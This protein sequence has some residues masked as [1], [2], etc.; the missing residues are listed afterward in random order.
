MSKGFRKAIIALSIILIAVSAVALTLYV[1]SNQVISG[2]LTVYVSI[3][4]LIDKYKVTL[5]GYGVVL[6]IEDYLIHPSRV[7]YDL[8]LGVCLLACD[9]LIEVRYIDILP[10]IGHV[11]IDS[12]LGNYRI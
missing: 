12:I 9:K 5:N 1:T 7:K 8:K 11:I 2:N 4:T 3:S 10:S 6:R